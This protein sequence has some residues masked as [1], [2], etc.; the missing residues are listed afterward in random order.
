MG[1]R[2]TR[3]LLVEDNPMD[4]RFVVE[5]LM[6]AR[7]R[8]TIEQ[9]E[10]LADAITALDEGDVDLVVLELNLPDSTSLET[11]WVVLAHAGNVPV[12]VLTGEAEEETV[13][14]AVHR[15]AQDYLLKGSDMPRLV[16]AV[17]FALERNGQGETQR[18]LRPHESDSSQ[19]QPCWVERTREFMVGGVLIKRFRQ[20]SKNQATILRAFEEEGW[21]QTIDDPLPPDGE[22]DPKERLRATI[23]SL[24]RHQSR[25][26]IHF[27]GDGTGQ[28]IC[29]ELRVGNSSRSVPP[30]S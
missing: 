19:W 12:V 30:R 9:V 20:S 28:V 11:C 24:N 14:E 2:C 16:H 13:I 5:A 1:I 6:S 29:W 17:Y 10:T 21:P 15:G 4:A 8:F 3:V 7:R 22:V 25:Q 18:D 26:L 23:K 27:S